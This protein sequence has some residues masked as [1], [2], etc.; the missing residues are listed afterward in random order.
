MIELT[1]PQING[2]IYAARVILTG[3]AEICIECRHL[4]ILNS[5]EKGDSSGHVARIFH[6]ELKYLCIDLYHVAW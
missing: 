1:Y 6:L 3:N 2:S 4:L 5:W